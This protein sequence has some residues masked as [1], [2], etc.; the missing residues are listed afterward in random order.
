MKS[1][2]ICSF[3]LLSPPARAGDFRLG[4]CGEMIGEE[5]T[6]D[7]HNYSSRQSFS[8]YM[9]EIRRKAMIEVRKDGDKPSGPMQDL[10]SGRIEHLYGVEFASQ[11]KLDPQRD[12]VDAMITSIEKVNSGDVRDDTP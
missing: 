1:A 5:L 11:C 9:Q 6:T 2:V 8:Q 4:S 12:A 7:F 10:D 3:I